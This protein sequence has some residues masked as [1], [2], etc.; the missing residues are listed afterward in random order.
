MIPQDYM[1]LQEDVALQRLEI[2]QKDKRIHNLLEQYRKA[3]ADLMNLS[4]ERSKE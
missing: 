3:N 1:Q 4:L 2:E